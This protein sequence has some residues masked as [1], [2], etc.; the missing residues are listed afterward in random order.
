M[1]RSHDTL[2]SYSGPRR[3]ISTRHVDEF[4]AE[5]RKGMWLVTLLWLP[6]DLNYSSK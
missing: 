4:V 1:V 3:P 2:L 6:Q 5:P